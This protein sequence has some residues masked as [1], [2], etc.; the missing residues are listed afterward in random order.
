MLFQHLGGVAGDPSCN[1]Q[2]SLMEGHR[3]DRLVSVF[4]ATHGR[5]RWHDLEFTF[6]PILHHDVLVE[7]DLVGG[8]DLLLPASLLLLRVDGGAR[9]MVVR[10]PALAVPVVMRRMAVVGAS[11]GADGPHTA[12]TTSVLHIIAAQLLEFR[13]ILYTVKQRYIIILDKLRVEWVRLRG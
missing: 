6:L 5:R 7:G 3:R 4:A 12:T 13:L 1:G 8:Q 10:G 9:P 2:I 11:T